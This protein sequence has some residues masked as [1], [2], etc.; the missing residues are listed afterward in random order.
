[1]QTCG[2][3]FGVA[4]PARRQLLQLKPLPTLFGRR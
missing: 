2:E 3:A 1:M 4:P